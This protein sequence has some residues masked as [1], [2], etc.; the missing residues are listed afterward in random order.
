MDPVL[1]GLRLRHTLE[2][3]SRTPRVGIR[4][5]GDIREST[6]IVREL[7]HSLWREL[8]YLDETVDDRRVVLHLVPERRSPER[9]HTMGVRGVE[10][11]LELRVGCGD[12]DGRL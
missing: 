3:E 10:D 1:H 4:G 11:D 5:G 2:E 6:V 9:D 12:H 8:P 7:D